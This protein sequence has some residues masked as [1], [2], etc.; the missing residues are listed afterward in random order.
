[1]LALVENALGIARD[2]GIFLGGAYLVYATF[3]ST[4]R[5]LVLPRAAS[6]WIS[7]T[8]LQ[9]L[10]K[11]F[12]L[13]LRFVHTY[14]DRDRIMAFFAPAYLLTLTPLWMIIVLVGYMG[15]FGALRDDT[16]QQLFYLSGSSLLT[17]GFAPVESVPEMTLAFSEAIVG[18]ILVA[19]LIAYLPSIYNSFSRRESAVSKLSVRGGAPPSSAEMIKR[20][21]RINE[22]DKLRGFWEDW[23][24]VFAEIEESH[25]SLGALV[26]FRSPNPAL[27]WITASGTV[28]DTAAIILSVVNVPYEPK[29]ALCLRSGFLALQRVALFFEIPFPVD[30]TFPAESISIT[31]SD[32]NSLCED[33]D[34]QGVPLKADLEQAWLDYAGWRVNYDQVLTGLCNL[35]MAPYTPWSSD[36]SPV[37]SRSNAMTRPYS[38]P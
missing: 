8:H 12:A 10:W 14:E 15:M 11:L 22:L 32:F 28:L 27:S 36:R 24:Q 37:A 23:E 26:F 5:T 16:W 2:I 34:Q 35:T 4:V 21:Y 20:M 19:L 29:A 7:R 9:L 17:L 31:R 1:M 38:S 18:L 33:L 13:R 25:S 6:D 30:P 3:V